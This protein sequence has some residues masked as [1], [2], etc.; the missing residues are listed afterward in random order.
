ML[1]SFLFPRAAF[2]MS[3]LLSPCPGSGCLQSTFVYGIARAR[4]Q[5]MLSWRPFHHGTDFP[6]MS[7]VQHVGSPLMRTQINRSGLNETQMW[8][9]SAGLDVRQL[10]LRGRFFPESHHF[11]N[12][13]HHFNAIQP[14]ASGWFGS[15]TQA[16]FQC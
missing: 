12:Q 8:N 3:F 14:N 2:I 1:E 16:R 13:S 6:H 4:L 10:R 9:V 11:R 15:K 5:C 7:P